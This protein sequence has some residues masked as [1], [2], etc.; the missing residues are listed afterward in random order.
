[1]SL[2]VA[3][4]DQSTCKVFSR[5]S[6]VPEGAIA[7]S[8]P[9]ELARAAPLQSLDKMRE[10]LLGARVGFSSNREEAARRLWYV[11]TLGAPGG[12]D[13][14][15]WQRRK[16]GFGNNKIAD[17]SKIELIQLCIPSNDDMVNLFYRKLAKQAKQIVQMLVD[18]GRSIWTNE[19]ANSIVLARAS[20]VEGKQ[21]A[22]VV[23]T[24]YKSTLFAKKILR[25]VSFAEFISR[26]EFEGVVLEIKED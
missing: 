4:I 22:L 10:Q 25:R 6:D 11:L 13:A 12:Y 1:M 21:G 8:S 14:N 26:P 17:V 20:E 9:E 23:F 18:D 5:L 3:F 24:Y 15:K 2:V 16:D 7:F 19:D